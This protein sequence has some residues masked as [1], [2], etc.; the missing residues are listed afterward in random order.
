[1]AYDK[2]E[3]EKI[4]LEMIE[5][6]KLTKISHLA[7]FMPCSRSTFYDLELDKSDIIKETLYKIRENKKK[8]MTDK[9]AESDNATLQIAAFKLMAD[10]DELT[11]LNSQK[12]EVEHSFTDKPLKIG[13]G[14]RDAE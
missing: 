12:T 13:Y 14:D 3:L 4:A 5:E 8:K 6:H 2:G 7:T 10:E 1:M 9:W 11:R